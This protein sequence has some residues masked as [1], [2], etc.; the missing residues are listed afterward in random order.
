MPDAADS[1]TLVLALSV[2]AAA[3]VRSDDPG[4]SASTVLTFSYA[5]DGVRC[6]G[7]ISLRLSPAD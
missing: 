6:D 7:E 1:L 2:D 5:V 3:F 4:C